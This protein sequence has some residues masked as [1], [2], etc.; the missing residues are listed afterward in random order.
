LVTGAELGAEDDH[1]A[2]VVAAEQLLPAEANP[3][4]SGP[5]DES[6]ADPFWGMR[7]PNGD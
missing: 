4:G 5:V 1:G 7:D 6:S 2:A 3:A